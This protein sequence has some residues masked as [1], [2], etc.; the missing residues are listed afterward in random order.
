[1]LV[2]AAVQLPFVAHQFL[3][4]VPVR[5]A[6]HL[7]GLVPVDIVAGTFG[8][9]LYGGGANA[10]L[11]L[12]LITVCAC[13]LGMWRQAA[14][15][16][17]TAMISV[18]V[19]LIPVML[20]SSKVALIYLPIVF[21]TIFFSDIVR[22]PLKVFIGG[23]VVAAL[24]MTML[25]SFTLLSRSS[26]V[27]TWEGLLQQ[28]YQQQLA[29]PQERADLYSGLS[30]WTVLTFW[31]Q[32]HRRMDPVEIL[33]GHGPG[34][35]RVQPEGLDLAQ[36]LAEKRYGGLTIGYTA[37]AALLWEV[38]VLGLVAVVSIFWLAFLQAGRL[39]QHYAHR[40][41]V[42]SGIAYGLRASVLMLALS[43]G[44]KDFFVF[45][46]P[47]QTLLMLVLGYLAAQTNLLTQV[48]GPALAGVSR[49]TLSPP[50]R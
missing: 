23:L 47:F 38:G 20:N 29:P 35:T 1:M 46:V 2:F 19:L 4:L 49:L 33:I 8:G 37:V 18:A 42:K 5:A 24:V 27:R 21:V 39:A 41:P 16:G 6:A 32:Q 28:T 30:R 36:T 31:A 26:N 14:V 11:S 3:F 13:L 22:H 48:K 43:L 10:V 17:P 9:A 7:P 12:F 15:S 25:A 34:A 45:H 44:H 50:I 40:D